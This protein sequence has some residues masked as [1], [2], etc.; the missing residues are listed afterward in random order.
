MPFCE[1]CGVKN[2]D[3][4]RFCVNCGKPLP[5]PETPTEPPTPLPPV[6]TP[7]QSTAPPLEANAPKAGAVVAVCPRC[8]NESYVIC[9]NCHGWEQISIAQ[10]K[11][12]CHCGREITGIR[13]KCGA[14]V[15]GKFF[16]KASEEEVRQQKAGEAQQRK[17]EAAA[18]ASAAKKATFKKVS[19]FVFA[20]LILSCCLFPSLKD[21]F[22]P[23]PSP[24]KEVQAQ[25]SKLPSGRPERQTLEGYVQKANTIDGSWVNP[26]DIGN[27]NREGFSIWL[28]GSKWT[29]TE[30]NILALSSPKYS[31]KME[32]DYGTWKVD[33]QGHLVLHCDQHNGESVDK[34]GV[35]SFYFR[36]GAERS[37]VL[38]MSHISGENFGLGLFRRPGTMD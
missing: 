20:I 38:E 32:T 33:L 7:P 6:A 34:T 4:H 23:P 30:E 25:I 14:A 29:H 5:V 19:P 22:L 12:L 28:K 26:T 21:F 3:L 18:S 35:Y 27:K 9:G 24:T 16:R 10:E 37:S 11:G 15:Y 2:D 8:G 1:Q 36:D 31:G 17:Q 13:C